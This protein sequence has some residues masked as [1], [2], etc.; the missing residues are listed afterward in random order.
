[1]AWGGSEANSCRA[2]CSGPPWLPFPSLRLPALQTYTALPW[3]PWDR[4]THEARLSSDALLAE[5][6][7]FKSFQSHWV[8][9]PGFHTGAAASLVSMMSF[10]SSFAL[11]A[12]VTS[13]L[14]KYHSE[15]NRA[16]DPKT[17]LTWLASCWVGLWSPPWTVSS[18]LSAWDCEGHH[19]CVCLM[20]TLLSLF[21]C[22][23]GHHLLM[24]GCY[25]SSCFWCLSPR[26]T[27][28]PEGSG[29]GLS[30]WVLVY[31]QPFS[32]GEIRLK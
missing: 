16:S 5:Q 10:P 30:R 15:M 23:P 8:S 26:I 2:P 17:H 24:W 4:Y 12:E 21:P 6:E 11:L 32:P 3:W 27:H 25:G 13:S 19:L 31:I 20:C 14:G 1:M 7:T 22:P 9:P 29:Y 28:C 18:L